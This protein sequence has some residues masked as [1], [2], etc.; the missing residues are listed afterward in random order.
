MLQVHACITILHKTFAGPNPEPNK[1]GYAFT[2][3]G[4]PKTFL[5][6]GKAKYDCQ[7][8]V[9]AGLGIL[10]DDTRGS[11]ESFVVEPGK[12]Y[13]FRLIAATTLSYF[14]FAIDGHK[15]TV[16]RTDGQDLKPF[17][18]DSIEITS[19]ERYDVLVTAD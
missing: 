4:D 17:T 14:N 7:V 10:C 16:I 19:G 13:L 6:N 1:Y 2:W 18:V 3:P 11:F 12:T 9:E 8:G 15:M 5:F